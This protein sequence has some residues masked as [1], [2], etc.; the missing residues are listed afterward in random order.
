MVHELIS[1]VRLASRKQSQNRSN[2]YLPK[3]IINNKLIPT[4]KIGEAF[5]YLGRYFDFNMSN[6]NHKME[7]TK[8]INELMTDIDSKL[9]VYSRYVLSKL[10]WHFAVATLSKTWVIT[11]SQPIH[12]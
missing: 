12:P 1:A 7:L 5:Q 10:S 9:L 3:L 11:R 4:T 6:D 8:L 2:T